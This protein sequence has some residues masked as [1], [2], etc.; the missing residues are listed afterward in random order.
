MPS[1]PPDYKVVQ[2]RR[3]T[4]LQHESFVGA[5]GEVT[6]NTDT[7]QAVVHDGETAGG[8]PLKV[9]AVEY[10][11][12]RYI[13]F[14]AALTQQGVASL[15]FSSPENAPVPIPILKNG[16]I[17]GAAVFSYL[18]NQSVQ[19]H[20]V[21]PV[22]WVPPISLEILWRSSLIFGSVTWQVELL[23]VSPGDAITDTTFNPAGYVTDICA[24]ESYA[25]TT[26]VISPLNTT[27]LVPGSEVFF[28]FSRNPYD[29]LVGDAELISLR[30][31]L[32]IQ[33]K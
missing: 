33:G 12:P 4:A 18:A 14:R 6:I 24:G 2:L 21:L 8:F 3:G 15:G 9:E 16:V 27:N 28:Q 23:G 22:D 31:I 19:D 29:T 13:T 20:F 25:F 17:S 26:S 32:Q 7:W 5:Q 10:D 11:R 1:Q 30:F